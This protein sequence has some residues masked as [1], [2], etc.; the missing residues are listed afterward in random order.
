MPLSPPVGLSSR[1]TGNGEDKNRHGANEE[2]TRWR[3]REVSRGSEVG[4]DS[5]N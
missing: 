4:F 5:G 1:N 2:H 3:I